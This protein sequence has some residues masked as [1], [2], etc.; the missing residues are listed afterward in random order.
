T[1]A[2]GPTGATAAPGTTPGA[3]PSASVPPPPTAAQATA[4]PA[5]T[6]APSGP[7]SATAPGDSAAFDG[8][9]PSGSVV[10][11]A[12]DVFVVNAEGA[13]FWHAG[14]AGREA[15]DPVQVAFAEPGTEIGRV[16]G[17]HD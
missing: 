17:V 7:A 8:V 14:L 4:P 9:V 12:G 10:P 3:D 13:L 16:A 1:Y 11:T 5:P 6:P 2:A 15:A